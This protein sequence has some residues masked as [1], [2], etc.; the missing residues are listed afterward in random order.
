MRVLSPAL[1]A[2]FLFLS[3]G[4]AWG[5]AEDDPL[6]AQ[7]A[8]TVRRHGLDPSSSLESRI[9]DA[10]TT[11][12]EMLKKLGRPLPMAHV[13]TVGERL[14]LSAAFEALP[15]LHRRV[16]RQRLRSVSFLDGMPNTALTLTVDPD[17]PYR[18]F[19]ITIRAG[20]LNEDISHW[21]TWK[22]RT[23]FEAAGSSLSVS[24]EAGTLDAILYVLLHEVTHVVDSSLQ[25]TPAPRP[26]AQPAANDPIN[27]FTDGVWSERSVHSPR[28]RD[29]LLERIPFRARAGPLPIGQAESVYGALRRTP[30]VSLYGS[31]NWHDD[32]AEYLALY[33]LTETLKQPYRIIISKE[34]KQIFVYEPMKS[35]LVRSRISVINQ[36]Y[37]NQD[38]LPAVK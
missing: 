3:G 20:I 32:L 15:P 38:Q 2:I 10:P 33:H 8:E 18:L 21:L 37:S 34:G 9:K 12:L 4:A 16:L 35:D 28:Y 27:L 36:F 1:A 23:C 11:V 13:L 5:E 6:S 31:S 17:E 14:K 19:D 22:E 29:P 7:R 24:I 25:I 30:F 26:G